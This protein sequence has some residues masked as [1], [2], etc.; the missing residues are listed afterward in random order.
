MSFERGLSHNMRQAGAPRTPDGKL[1]SEN[2]LLGG[3]MIGTVMDDQDEQRAGRIWVSLPGNT[4]RQVNS[5][6][7]E[8][9]WRGTVPDRRTGRLEFDAELRRNWVLCQPA[10]ASMGSDMNRADFTVDGRNS[11]RGD[12]NSY[13]DWSQPR[14]GDYVT[15]MFIGGDPNLAVY[16]GCLGK[17]NQGRMIPGNAGYNAKTIVDGSEEKEKTKS[18]VAIPGYD[19]DFGS[20]TITDKTGKVVEREDQNGKLPDHTSAKTT[21]LSGQAYDKHRGPGT[22]SMKRESPS[23]VRGTKTAGWNYETERYNTNQDGGQFQK[24]PGKYRYV[25]TTGHQF[26][27]DDHPDHQVIRLR[28]SGG[29]QILLN[30]SVDHPYLY[31]STSKGNVWMEFTDEG[32]IAMYSQDGFSLHAKDI[33]LTADNDINMEAFNDINMI[34]RKNF[35]MTVGKETHWAFNGAFKSIYKERVDETFMD[36]FFQSIQ[37]SCNTKIGK[38]FTVKAEGTFI[39]SSG[40][41]ISFKA[42]RAAYFESKSLLSL[43]SRNT[44]INSGMVVDDPD[45]DVM[46]AKPKFG[47]LTK[48]PSP[49]V[50]DEILQNKAPPKSKYLAPVVPQ[51]QPWAGREGKS[52][53]GTTGRVSA[54]PNTSLAETNIPGTSFGA[55]TAVDGSAT[56]QRRVGAAC[57]TATIPDETVGTKMR[58]W[59][60]VDLRIANYA[61]FSAGLLTS[62]FLSQQA[63]DPAPMGIWTPDS[64]Y[65]SDNIQEQPDLVL[66]RWLKPGEIAPVDSYKCT[67]TTK[68][69]IKTN[70]KLMQFPEVIDGTIYVGRGHRVKIGETI[71]GILITSDVYQGWIAGG[72]TSTMVSMTSDECDALFE[73]DIAFYEDYV[74]NNVT[75]LVTQGQYD[76]LVSFA[77]HDQ[78]LSNPRGATVNVISAINIGRNDIALE[79]IS[80]N[81]YVDGIVNGDVVERRQHERNIFNTLPNDNMDYTGTDWVPTGNTV[82]L[83]DFTVYQVVKDAIDA[84]S[85]EHSVNPIFMYALCAQESGFN[86]NAKNTAG[87]QTGLFQFPHDAA[88]FYEIEGVETDPVENAGA[89]AK[90]IKDSIEVFEEL[91]EETPTSQ[92]LYMQMFMGQVGGAEFI[93]EVLEHPNN[94]AA[95]TVETILPGLV[96]AVPT[97]FYKYDETARTNQQVY[98]FLTGLI[99]SRLSLF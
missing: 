59:T 25:N 54:M 57:S 17:P 31:V 79:L 88:I 58:S 62:S 92:D 40:S 93:K 49:P 1:V 71:D 4:S 76:A 5:P 46:V 74:R 42:E 47:E 61:I 50:K 19:N 99:G 45:T 64:E 18:S 36:D 85:V 75:V 22:S 34:A 10:F 13:G 32:K 73:M 14:I 81:V 51:H 26:V 15:V 84:A 41:T 87:G 65:A 33:N 11:T 39:V 91:I 28:T 8:P 55:T 27:M 30:D 77:Y 89:A 86:P 68:N 12:V 94:P 63:R 38:D 48:K 98:D 37:G 2:G 80:Q 67:S 53:S 82:A 96:D 90:Y 9:H 6:N 56:D 60:N 83:S 3:L 20:S 7:V 66:Q 70:E 72:I 16:T 69:F 29:T 24:N 44:Y 43:E 52:T 97:V 95:T 35:R 23:Y 21:I 78:V